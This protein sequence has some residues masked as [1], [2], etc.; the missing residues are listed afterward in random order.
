MQQG[1]KLPFGRE[2]L[3]EGGEDGACVLIRECYGG[4][5]MNW[6]RFYSEALR[7]RKIAHISRLTGIDRATVLGVWTGLLCLAS[8]SPCRGSL[9]LA[10]GVPVATDE[11]AEE[12]GI[13]QGK[14]AVLVNAFLALDM[15]NGEDG[16]L[17]VTH[18]PERQYASDSS[19][20][21]VRQHRQGRGETFQ[22]RG[23][24]VSETGKVQTRETLQK[25]FR[26][27]PDTD[28]DP[29]T[30]TETDTEIEALTDRSVR[31][32]SPSFGRRTALAPAL[33]DTDQQPLFGGASVGAGI[34]VLEPSGNADEDRP[35]LPGPDDVD[36]GSCVLAAQQS[37][38]EDVSVP[39]ASPS[40]G[41]AAPLFPPGVP[42]VVSLLPAKGPGKKARRAAAEV[43]PR[44]RSPAVRAVHAV[45]GRMPH[46]DTF[47]V[48]IETVGPEPDVGRMKTCWSHWR[49]RHYSPQNLDWLLDWYVNGIPERGSGNGGKVHA[50]NQGYPGPSRG[51]DPREYYR[52]SLELEST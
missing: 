24:N 8:E 10:P 36:K 48:I 15:L 18:W 17:T 41:E 4:P 40:V 19:T 44:S 9:Y 21:R 42:E 25:R 46:K 29:D 32:R 1:T 52:R 43:D 38:E 45:T 39:G 23:R 20:A 5:W 34:A 14:M 3:T 37:V 27:G 47:D 13:E 11:V 2:Y 16:T 51:A 12:V 7:D 35:V 33:T 26:N 6:F 30:D 22:T 31:D 28:T 49:A 50:N